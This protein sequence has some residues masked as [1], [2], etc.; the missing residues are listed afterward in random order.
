MMVVC[1][2][3]LGRSQNSEVRIRNAKC[4]V[5]SAKWRGMVKFGG[6]MAVA[7][8]VAL[9]IWSPY[10]L[11]ERQWYHEGQGE[12]A[13]AGVTGASVKAELQRRVM[14]QQGFA[15]PMG[16]GERMGQIKENVLKVLVPDRLWGESDPARGWLWVYLT[17]GVL[18]LFGVGVV[19]MG[20]RRQ[21]RV[22]GFLAGWVGLI[23]GPVVVFGTVM[24]P[25]YAL[26]GVLPMLV[27]VGYLLAD[28]MGWMLN[29]CLTG[30]L[31][32][33]AWHTVMAAGLVGVVIVW[34]MRDMRMQASRWWAMPM[35][36]QDRYQYVTGW[37]AGGGTR[38]AIGTLREAAG[39]GPIVVITND[40]WGTPGDAVWAYLE[41]VP[42]VSVYYVSGAGGPVRG[43]GLGKLW[44]REKKWTYTPA[45]VVELPVGAEVYYVSADPVYTG[46]GP[47]PAAEML[48]AEGV[49][50]VDAKVFANVAPPGRTVATDA[51]S[52]FDLGKAGESAAQPGLSAPGPVVATI[53]R[54]GLAPVPG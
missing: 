12:V 30:P 34:P 38:E 20:V 26:A 36:E 22:L 5:R 21:W 14:Y 44:L 47:R 45:R 9:V 51:V 27:V 48:E 40:G 49:Q 11:A 35:V 37:P 41:K 6:M 13:G 31:P 39:R 10:L 15:P 25:R 43:A 32:R 1:W 18:G 3:G 33:K 54:T 52:V 50:V 42:G 19:W 7:L 23:L 29:A 2:L 16:L 4:E 53:D 17:P 8:G 46:T 24:F 28:V